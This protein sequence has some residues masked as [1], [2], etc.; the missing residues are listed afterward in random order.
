MNITNVVFKQ[1]IDDTMLEHILTLRETRLGLAQKMLENLSNTAHQLTARGLQTDP[2][3]MNE[4]K[5]ELID[6]V[7]T[8]RERLDHPDF[9]YEDEIAMYS[10]MLVDGAPRD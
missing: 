3:D 10:D 6:R 5:I 2:I 8:M 9:I 7:A 4:L 1:E